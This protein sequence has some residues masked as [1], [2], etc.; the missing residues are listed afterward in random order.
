MRK[1]FLN[2]MRQT[3][4]GQFFYRVLLA[5][6]SAAITI[7]LSFLPHDTLL[8]AIWVIL[9][10]LY[11][12]Y[13]AMHQRLNESDEVRY[14]RLFR[15]RFSYLERTDPD[16]LT[17]IFAENIR[18][19]VLKW[20]EDEHEIPV[21]KAKKIDA[22]DSL[23]KSG[24]Q[25]GQLIFR[26]GVKLGQWTQR[27]KEQNQPA[28]EFIESELEA[29]IAARTEL[30]GTEVGEG[31]FLREVNLGEHRPTGIHLFH[32]KSRCLFTVESYDAEKKRRSVSLSFKA[33]LFESATDEDWI[34]FKQKVHDAFPYF[35]PA[36]GGSGP[37]S[38]QIPFFVSA[39]LD[40]WETLRDE[41]PGKLKLLMKP[42][43][44]KDASAESKSKS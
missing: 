39:T 38:R 44:V 42:F 37:Q 25:H 30:L 11:I 1:S 23:A 33:S 31:I 21:A 14:R 15:S 16:A 40:N 26:T 20:F 5:V 27:S 28:L 41:V 9:S 35:Q 10:S 13:V 19:P 17:T 7:G 24:D 43:Q 6:M 18:P 32:P 3:A 8:Q 34:A 29:F 4:Y 22:L 12:G 36:K 2:W